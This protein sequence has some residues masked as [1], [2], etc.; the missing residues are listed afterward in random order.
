MLL[1]NKAKALHLQRRISMLYVSKKIRKRIRSHGTNGFGSGTGFFHCPGSIIFLQPLTQSLTLILRLARAQSKEC[2]NGDGSKQN[3][4]SDGSASFHFT[5]AFAAA[6]G[7][8]R[9]R[10]CEAVLRT[11]MSSSRSNGSS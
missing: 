7:S 10:A 4:Q 11:R 2:R 5:P 1:L 8:M 6:S 9:L 3:N